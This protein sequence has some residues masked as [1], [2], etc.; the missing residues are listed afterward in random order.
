M[1]T[2]NSSNISNGNVIEPNDLLQL[3]DAFTAGGG[4]TGAYN[5]SLSGSLTG[6]ATTALNASK[7]NPTLNASTNANYNVL[8]AA[9]SSADY[10]TVYKEDGNI[11]TYNPSTNLLNVTSSRA[12]TASFALNGGVADQIVSQGYSN[13]AAG[14]VEATFK[15]YAGKVRMVTNS[16]TT[17][18]FPGLAGK[19]LGTNVWVTA[20]IQ[21]QASSFAAP[22]L[23]TVRSLSANGA[24]TIETASVPDTTEVHFHVIY[25]P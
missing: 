2:L 1:A 22:N 6:S 9:T 11:M 14:P 8:F 18:D 25:V 4:T 15:F 21:G 12:V 17:A 20:T 10:E 3:Y 13:I 24:I 5:V 16:G 19:T 7:L 23:V